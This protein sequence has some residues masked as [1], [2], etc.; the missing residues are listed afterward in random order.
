VTVAT[1][2]VNLEV[3]GN[4]K[5]IGYFI[6]DD[7]SNVETGKTLQE[8]EKPMNRTQCSL[9]RGDTYRGAST[10][11]RSKGPTS[12]G[13]SMKINSNQPNQGDLCKRDHRQELVTKGREAEQAEGRN[14]LDRRRKIWMW[15]VHPQCRGQ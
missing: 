9:A 2:K 7:I 14:E 8:G 10:A 1:A 13:G 11:V 15:K 3:R 5:L 12:E 6:C 4:S